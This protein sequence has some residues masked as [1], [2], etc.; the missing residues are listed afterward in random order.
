MELLL[1][2]TEERDKHVEVKIKTM[3]EKMK[4]MG[5]E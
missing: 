1:R 3:G 5:E 4:T 2:D